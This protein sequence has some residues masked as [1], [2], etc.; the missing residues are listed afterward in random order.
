M[1]GWLTNL[2]VIWNLPSGISIE[3]TRCRNQSVGD[4]ASFSTP[5]RPAARPYSSL[6]SA[7]SILPTPVM[8]KE[9]RLR[10]NEIKYCCFMKIDCFVIFLAKQK[11]KCYGAMNVSKE[12]LP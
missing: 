6:P 10:R 8:D 11:G 4:Y 9:K 1:K 2:L 3:I 12:S 7:C 5:Y